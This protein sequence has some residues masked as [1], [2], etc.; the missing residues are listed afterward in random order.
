MAYDEL[1]TCSADLREDSNGSRKK[2]EQKG[3]GREREE[4]GEVRRRERD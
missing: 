1:G 2:R 4:K 3:K